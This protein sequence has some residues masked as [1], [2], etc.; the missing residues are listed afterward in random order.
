MRSIEFPYTL[1]KGIYIPVI[2]VQLLHL[3]RWHKKWAFVDSGATYSIFSAKEALS[4]DIDFSASTQRYVIVG[5][6]GFI[7]AS[8]VKLPVRI[9]DVELIAEVGFSEKLGIGFNLLGR[10]DVF[11]RF[12]VCFSDATKIVSFHWDETQP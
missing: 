9:G 2:P 10:K 1:Y 4:M 5:D 12:R 11:D 8:F 7:P 6:G 3:G